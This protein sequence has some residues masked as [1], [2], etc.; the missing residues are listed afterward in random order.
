MDGDWHW[1]STKLMVE[2]V[3]MVSLAWDI[4]HL[5]WNSI[6]KR[7]LTNDLGGLGF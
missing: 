4:C 2:T 7:H 6:K 1:N 5:H 3:N